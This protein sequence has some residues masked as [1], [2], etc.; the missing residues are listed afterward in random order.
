MRLS[1]KE[2]DTIKQKALER[3]GENAKVYIFGSRLDDCKR[4]GD[5]DIFIQ[6]TIIGDLLDLKIEYLQSLE[7]ELGEQ[8][9]DVLIDDGKSEKEIY[10][11][12]AKEGVRL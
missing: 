7:K 3:F 12:A 1:H 8:K 11:I 6:S 10:K 4:G 9:I 5:I 2:I